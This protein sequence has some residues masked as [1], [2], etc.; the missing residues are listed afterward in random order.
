MLHD[1]NSS[2]ADLTAIIERIAE[3]SQTGL[4]MILANGDQA[5]V[6]FCDGQITGAMHILEGITVQLQQYIYRL[7][8]ID[9]IKRDVLSRMR[10]EDGLSFEEVLIH[11]GVIEKHNIRNVIIFKIKEILLEMLTWADIS[12]SFIPGITL[13]GNSAVSVNLQTGE[14]TGELSRQLD[15]WRQI[16]DRFSWRELQLI[17]TGKAVKHQMDRDQKAIY[18]IVTI[19]TT[20]ET[21]VSCSGLGRYRTYRA[22]HSM[23]E[24]GLLAPLK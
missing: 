19:P 21:L 6:A 16:S 24:A 15:E 9:G 20:M 23:L 2:G 14:I 1:G 8:L 10:D 11:G 4:L 18:R 13:Y 22:A 12:Y 17:P 5:Q 3:S 7:G